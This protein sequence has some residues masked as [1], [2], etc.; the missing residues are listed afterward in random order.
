MNEEQKMKLEISRRS[1]FKGVS[2]VGLLSASS[3]LLGRP[4]DAHSVSGAETP[5][6]GPIVETQNGKVRGVLKDG[7]EEFRGIPY[8]ATTHGSNRFMPPQPVESWTG[9]REALTCGSP[10]P[11][12]NPWQVFYVDPQPMSEDCLVLNVW[13]SLKN[14]MFH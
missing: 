13:F 3:A 7:L 10:C 9:V 8:G 6:C 14:H 1:L 12:Y 11:Q 2:G 5:G 4:A